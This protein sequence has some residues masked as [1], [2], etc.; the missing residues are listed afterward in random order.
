[1]RN[2][3]IAIVCLVVGLILS[4]TILPD[5]VTDTAT[6]AYAEPY[7]ITTGVGETNTTKRLSFASYYDDLTAL[8]ADSDNGND[9]PVVLSYDEDTQDVTVIGLEAS[10]SRI[11]TISYLRE[12]HHEF[13]G[14]A[15]FL[16]FLPFFCIAGLVVI[17][18]WTLFAGV[19]SRG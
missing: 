19:R 15:P 14:F 3:L 6:E 2:V 11:L 18:L 9:T 8:D 12:A 7:S 10:A 1:M 5:V 13:L 16:R 4:A 17:F